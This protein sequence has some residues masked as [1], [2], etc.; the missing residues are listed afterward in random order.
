MYNLST[1]NSALADT[2][3]AGKLHFSPVTQS[4]NTDALEAARA[5]APQGSVFFAD[6]QLAGRGRGAHAWHSAAGQ[7]LYASVLLRPSIPAARL[8]MLALA[9]GLAAASAIHRI[10]ALSV[11]IRWPNDLLVGQRKAGGI[12]VEGKTES[13]EVAFAVVGIGINVHQ[14]DFPADVS[15]PATSLD[16]ASGQIV[17]RQSLLIALLESL[18]QEA[19]ALESP[20]TPLAIRQRLQQASSWINGRRVQVHGPQTCTGITAGLDENGF[21]RVHTAT[22]LVTVHTGG[23]R[24]AETEP[25]QSGPL[26]SDPEL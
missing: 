18:A 17:S 6:E 24:A 10:A 15:T 1:L 9:A 11:D 20:A 26:P 4:T 12:L 8:P 3:Y 25:L 2:I 19:L 5:E 22:G 13:D 23:L 14:R 7:G 21:L 16:Q